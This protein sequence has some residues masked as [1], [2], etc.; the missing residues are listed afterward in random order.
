M[1]ISYTMYEKMI[2]KVKKK[3]KIDLSK[4]RGILK[5]DIGTDDARYNAIMK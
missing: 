4:F 5:G 1:M 2:I 3:K